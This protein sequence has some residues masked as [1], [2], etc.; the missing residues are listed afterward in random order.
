MN[1]LQV[2]TIATH[3]ASD[4]RSSMLVFIDG[5]S[6]D[7]QQLALSTLPL[8]ILWSLSRML[9]SINH[10]SDLGLRSWLGK[11]RIGNSNAG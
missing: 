10:D 3:S 8:S 5:T 9:R 2:P 4:D 11:G 7:A 6:K 1:S